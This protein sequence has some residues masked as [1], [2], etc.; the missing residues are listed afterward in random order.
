M[1]TESH[2]NH[3]ERATIESD[4]AYDYSE[5]QE[6]DE[7]WVEENE[8]ADDDERIVPLDDAEEEFREEDE[9]L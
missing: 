2:A 8:A 9:E 6:V 1:D 5:D 4:P 7:A 3:P